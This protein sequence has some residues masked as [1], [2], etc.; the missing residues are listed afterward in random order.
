MELLLRKK[1]GETNC[2]GRLWDRASSPEQRNAQ[3]TALS[4]LGLVLQVCFSGTCPFPAP[5]EPSSSSSV[6]SDLL[7]CSS[8]VSVVPKQP[9]ATAGVR[10]Q[11]L[12][13]TRAASLRFCAAVCSFNPLWVWGR[14]KAVSAVKRHFQP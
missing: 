6:S 9:K 13:Q 3:H 7:S 14:G 8:P 11:V 4:H 12:L 1:E 5:T 10:A 2:K